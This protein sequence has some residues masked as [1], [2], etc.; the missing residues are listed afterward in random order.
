MPLSLQVRGRGGER[1]SL[2]LGV[3]MSFLLSVK[4]CHTQTPDYQAYLQI[5]RFADKN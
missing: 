2:W 4:I 1:L 3:L 5:G